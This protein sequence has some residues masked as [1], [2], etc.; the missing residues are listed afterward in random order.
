MTKNFK[1]GDFVVGDGSFAKIL[2]LESYPNDWEYSNGW[3]AEVELISSK[4]IKRWPL[5][6]IQIIQ[7]TEEHLI[8]MGFKKPEH[9]KNAH[10]LAY[11]L[12]DIIISKTAI[13][14]LED[15]AGYTVVDEFDSGFCTTDFRKLNKEDIIKYKD[16]D[17]ID[18]KKFYADFHCVMNINRLFD[19]LKEE[20]KPIEEEE[21]MRISTLKFDNK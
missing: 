17:F 11:M 9:Q 13:H 8:K 10:V 21:K 12:D 16:A 4:E 20:G 14:N 19:Y 3:V 2:K 15:I 1:V 18:I 6:R 5:Y 7:T